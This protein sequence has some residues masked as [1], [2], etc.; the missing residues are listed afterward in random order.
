MPVK[1]L[2][3]RFSSIGDI[4]LTTPVI[5]CLKQQVEGA[6]VHFLTKKKFV[7]LITANPY[8]DRIH[9]FEG[10]RQSAKALKKEGFDYIIDLHNNLRSAL[11]KSALPT[12]PFSFRKL[13][14]EKWLLV[15][16]K[17]DNLPGI[18]IVDRYLDTLKLFD[19]V[20]DGRGIDY[21]IP[22]GDEINISE[23]PSSFHEGYVVF[24]TGA[25]HNTKKLPAEKITAICREMNVPVI[26]AGGKE[27]SAIA[28]SVAGE[29]GHLVINGCG[30]FNINE[31]ASLVRQAS[32]IITHDTGLMH[33]AAAF[34]KK[35][36][37]VWGNTIP[38]FGMYPYMP[39]P[40]SAIFE[41][42]GLRCRPC[43]KLGFSKCPKKHFRCMLDQDVSEIAGY[44]VKL[45]RRS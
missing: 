10:I 11:I 43:S 20:N 17:K 4:V 28:E 2:I 36:I 14:I 23:F 18:H 44:A 21:F 12:I 42:G 7:P 40:D 41:V 24:A 31:S 9:E 27:D 34:K 45:F 30:L 37:S 35:I 15:N 5:R 22:P 3:I 6:E 32:V 29:C 13:N 25:N 38:R 1:F 16:F 8:I 26:L 33:I 39:H 19:V